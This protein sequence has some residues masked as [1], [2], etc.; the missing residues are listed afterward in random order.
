M[1]AENN[2]IKG[3]HS[4]P[5]K[6]YRDVHQAKDIARRYHHKTYGAGSADESI[7][8]VEQEQLKDTVSRLVP[9][10]SRYL[11]FAC[12]TGRIIGF[13]GELFETPTGVD[14]SAAMLE[15]TKAKAPRAKLIC[16]D[17]SENEN[18]VGGDYDLI[19]A[20]RFFLRAQ[21]SLREALMEI[22]AKKLASDGKLIFNI[23]NSRPSLLWVQNSIT[24][25]FKKNKVLSMSRREVAH[26]IAEAGLQII[27]THEVGVLPKVLHLILGPKIWTRLDRT[28]RKIKMLRRLA[29]HVIYVCRRCQSAR[30]DLGH[31]EPAEARYD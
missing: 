7:W 20:F 10:R 16:G 19:T 6:D 8:A 22:L 27:E 4:L 30:G 12:G 2:K 23:H 24:N 18:L 3:G 5:Q 14:I 9:R 17:I 31:S 1:V 15:F 11:D 13:I 25:L 28:L 26:L 29:S 21:P